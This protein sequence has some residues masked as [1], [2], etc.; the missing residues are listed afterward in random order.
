MVFSY[1]LMVFHKHVNDFNNYVY[2]ISI[3]C[4]IS[5]GALVAG[6]RFPNE[7]EVSVNF[8]YDI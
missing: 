5:E 7:I 2:L 8:I 3:Y 1:S 6:I 4:L